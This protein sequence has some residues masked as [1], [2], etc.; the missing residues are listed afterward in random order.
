MPARRAIGLGSSDRWW[1]RQT[2]PAGLPCALSVREA[3]GRAVRTAPRSAR[4]AERVRR[5]QCVRQ[6]AGRRC[7][8]H[9][10]TAAGPVGHGDGAACGAGGH[11]C[12]A[13]LRPGPPRPRLRAQGRCQAPVR[14]PAHALEPAG[15][16]RARCMRCTCRPQNIMYVLQFAMLITLRTWLMCMRLRASQ[17]PFGCQAWTDV[18][19]EAGHRKERNRAGRLSSVARSHRAVAGLDP[20]TRIR[21]L[22]SAP[23]P[24]RAQRPGVG[25]PRRRRGW[26]R[27]C[28]AAARDALQAAAMA[29]GPRSAERCAVAAL[30]SVSLWKRR[31]PA[32]RPSALDAACAQGRRRARLSR[33]SSRALGAPRQPLHS[34]GLAPVTHRCRVGALKIKP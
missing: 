32:R 33:H 21:E 3:Q 2:R 12:V 26:A 6:A 10:R 24:R 29:P 34:H 14:I 1:R 11:V 23:A 13:V 8:W 19:R 31:R 4:C 25:A 30:L 7:C 16:A 9:A 17:Q 20:R 27:G 22:S 15:C 5:W 18:L 28:W